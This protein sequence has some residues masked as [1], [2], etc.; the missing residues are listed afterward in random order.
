MPEIGSTL[1][2]ARLRAKID[3]T[4]VE[5]ATKIRTKYLRALEDED[6]EILPG[7]TFTKSFLRSYAEYLGLDARLL[8]EQ[9]KARYERPTE[10]EL[11]PPLQSARRRERRG[12]RP[13]WVSR[14]VLGG[15]IVALIVAL[16]LLGTLGGNGSSPSSSAKKSPGPSVSKRHRRRRVAPRR[17][18]IR[19]SLVP[20]G[21]VYICLVNARGRRLVPGVTLPAG[22][23][24]ARFGSRS[25]ELTLG[26]NN[27]MMRVDGRT[28]PVPASATP[29]GYRIAA[30]RR[31]PRRTA[32]PAGQR[33]TCG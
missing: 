5:R 19:L 9:F 1:R 12:P 26:N 17:R 7:P 23:H 22:A 31:G 33:P 3:I 25:F 14:A 6:W 10:V 15:L 2:D 20:T 32:L 29:I 8:V 16:A 11:A 21:P 18:L 13:P 27:V 28:L 4:E 30:G 24:L